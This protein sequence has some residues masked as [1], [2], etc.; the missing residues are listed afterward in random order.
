MPEGAVNHVIDVKASNKEGCMGTLRIDLKYGCYPVWF[1]D[2]SGRFVL[3]DLPLEL[4]GER[5]IE[6]LFC[7]IRDIY[8]DLFQVSGEG[9]VYMGFG[10]EEEKKRFLALV[11]S[12][13]NLIRM[14][15]A[16]LYS[17]EKIFDPA[18]L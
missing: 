18:K 13:V 4:A 1:Y 15:T 7:E 11:D 3:N 10:G 9:S 5:D 17:I 16:D 12:A 2:D 8:D 6:E 14:R